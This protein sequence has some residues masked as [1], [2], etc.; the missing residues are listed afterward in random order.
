MQSYKIT[1]Q[2]IRETRNFMMACEQRWKESSSLRQMESF[3]KGVIE[4]EGDAA[5][6]SRTF[7]EDT[8]TTQEENGGSFE[9]FLK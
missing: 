7:S 5:F 2:K 4:N 3:F 9:K 1:L 6:K 8:N